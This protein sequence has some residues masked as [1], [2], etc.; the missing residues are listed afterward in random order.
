MTADRRRDWATP[1]DREVTPSME[2]QDVHNNRGRQCSL[3]GDAKPR[4]WTVIAAWEDGEYILA[5]A[6][7]EIRFATLRELRNLY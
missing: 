4:Q 5:N 6:A 1:S 2:V 7:N 3:A